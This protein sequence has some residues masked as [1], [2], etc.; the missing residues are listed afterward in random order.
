MTQPVSSIV[1]CST[2]LCI[3]CVACKQLGL[4]CQ[5]L[6]LVGLCTSLFLLSV[7]FEQFCLSIFFSREQLGLVFSDPLQQL[8]VGFPCQQLCLYVLHSSFVFVGPLEQCPFF[9]ERLRIFALKW[10]CF[11]FRCHLHLIFLAFECIGLCLAFQLFFARELSDICI[12]ISFPCL[13][14]FQCIGGPLE[15]F[16]GF[17]C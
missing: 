8:C 14:I 1:I 12:S 6:C 10:L 17:P 2:Q 9:C 13:S 16:L 15:L 7:A 5:Q 4:P 11:A 3:L